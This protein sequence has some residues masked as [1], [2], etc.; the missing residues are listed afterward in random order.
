VHIIETLFQDIRL[1]LRMLRKSPGFTAVAILTLALGIGANTAIF[2]LVDGV[3]LQPLPYRE[4][5]R[6]TI[7]W[8]QDDHSKPD[9]VGYA[10]YLDWKAQN[11]SFQDLALYSS[12]QPILQTGE[13]EQLNGLR[14]TNNYFRTLG[15]HMEIGR[16]FLPEEDN[17]ASL[18]VVILSHALWARKFNSDPNIVG[19]AIAMNATAYVVAGV[20]PT[21]YQSLMNQDPRGGTVEI[22]RVLGYD[23]SQPW[24]CR[25]CHHLVAIGRLRPGVSFAE[26]KAEMDTISAALVKAYPKEYSASGVILT[27]LREQLLGEAST[28]LYILLGAVSF[29][30]L[31]ACANL[32]NLLLARSAHREREIAMRTAL[33]AG[34]GRIVQQLLVENCLLAL[35]GAA[36]GLIPAYLTP[37]FLAAV[38]TGGLPRL[39]GVQLDWRVLTFTAFAAL[40]TGI[41][42]GL[43]PAYRLS[44]TEVNESLKK[45]ARRSSS[46]ASRVLH[47]MMVVSE[48][49]L[50]LTLLIGAGLLL[51]S[52]AQL[53]MVSPG[54]D[55]THVLTLRTSVLGQRFNDNNVLRQ[56][57]K[58]AVERLRALPGV[59]A[60]AAA[61]QIPLGGNMDE[62]GFHPEGKINANPELDES[63]ERYCITPGFLATLRIPLFRGRDIAPTDISDSPGVI[64][65]NETTAK[66]IWPTEDPLGKRVKVGGL[67]HPWLTVIGVVGDVHHAGLDAAPTM[68]I[69]IPHAQWPFPDNDM[70]FVIRT[71]GPPSVLAPAARQAIHSLDS[72]QLLSRVMPL[73][74][75]VALSVQGRRF[76]L[77]LIGAFAAIALLLSMVGIYGVT[78]YSVAQRTREIGIRMALGAQGSEVMGLLLRQGMALIVAGVLLGIAASLGLTR[79]LASMLF[80]VRP[81]DPTTF[82]L[83]V[84]LLIIVAAL[85]CWIPARRTMRVDP[86]VALRY[87]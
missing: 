28:P 29:V 31:V 74:D 42:S 64:L 16:D 82:A 77:I 66:R 76:A 59:Q 58:D 32:A 56:Y 3:L 87:E 52:L 60:A 85:A 55:V 84:T 51:R 7:V 11:R 63:A 72:T 81:T 80:D 71:T 70:T 86:M 78:A 49:T 5:S 65:I 14:V 20:L 45:G 41:F 22:W 27:P 39:D 46:K 47:A 24:A 53:L 54:F 44:K 13:P 10:T 79:F 35:L 62:Y 75:Y 4:P 21:S 30:L 43:V 61:S 19:K 67:D 17:A 57:F 18:H 73:E 69:Y 6:L 23:V 12:W 36:V 34:R 33:G 48:V 83:V 26:A 2:S 38:G 15:I 9:N 40:L 25:T 37:R 8:E 68:Q 50:S 1:G